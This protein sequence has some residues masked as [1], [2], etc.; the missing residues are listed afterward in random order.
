MLHTLVGKSLVRGDSVKCNFRLHM[1]ANIICLPGARAPDIE[2]NLGCVKDTYGVT[3]DTPN[4][5]TRYENIVSCRHKLYQD[6]NLK[7]QKAI[8]SHTAMWLSKICRHRLILFGPWRVRGNDKHYSRLTSL[9]HC[10][11]HYEQVLGFVDNWHSM[12]GHPGM[13]MR[14]CLK[15]LG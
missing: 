5:D 7:S 13:L 9:N 11:A 14:D 6:E 4:T 12:W 15:A 2:A 10:L 8:S 1:P 3:L